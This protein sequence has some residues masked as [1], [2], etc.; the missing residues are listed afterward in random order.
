MAVS[1]YKMAEWHSAAAKV[2]PENAEAHRRSR[3]DW[4]RKCKAE[5]V[6]MKEQG[7]LASGDAGVI[8]MLDQE[9]AAED[10]QLTNASSANDD[11]PED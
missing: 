9:L 2:S 3:I 11:S 1:Y 4:L 5:F 6:A 7:L 8:P 10:T